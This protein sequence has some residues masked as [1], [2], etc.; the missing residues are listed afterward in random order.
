MN[1]DHILSQLR[2]LSAQA[3]LKRHDSASG[4]CNSLDCGHKY[5]AEAMASRFLELDESL[6]HGGIY[7]TDWASPI[8]PAQRTKR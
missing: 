2:E 3:M 6:S 7:P 8:I 1:P 4:G 5:R